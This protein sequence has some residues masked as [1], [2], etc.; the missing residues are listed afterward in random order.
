MITSF[1][2][3]IRLFLCITDVDLLNFWVILITDNMEST[4]PS[5]GPISTF[6]YLAY[7]FTGTFKDVQNVLAIK[8]ANIPF[9]LISTYFS[10]TTDAHSRYSRPLNFTEP[11]K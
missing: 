4:I 5:Q 1:V 6:F 7:F 9:Y 2:L 8:M 3:I 10:K 11:T